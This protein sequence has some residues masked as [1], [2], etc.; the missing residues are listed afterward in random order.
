MSWFLSAVFLFLL[1]L[2]GL[3]ASGGRGVAGDLASYRVTDPNASFFAVD[4]RRNGS[5]PDSRTVALATPLAANGCPRQS[6]ARP[7]DYFVTIPAFYQDRE[8]WREANA[9]FFAF[10]AQVTGFAANYVRTG[11]PGQ[12]H[13]LVH[14]LSSWADRR[15]LL[16]FDYEGNHGQAWYAIQWATA[17]AGLAYSI[18]RS[19]PSLSDQERQE[20]EDWLAA[21]VAKQIGYPGNPISCCNN[22]YY[23]RGLQAAIVGV[24]TG[25]DRLFRYGIRAYQAA[26]KSMNPD[27]SLRHEMDRGKRALHYQNFAILP[28]VFIAE[29]AARQGYDLYGMAIDGRDIHLAVGFLLQAM[30][31]PTV[32]RRYTS[33]EQD[34]RFI[35]RRDELNW[36]E[37]YHRRFSEPVIARWLTRL[38]PLSHNWTGGPGTLYFADLRATALDRTNQALWTTAPLQITSEQRRSTSK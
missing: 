11:E 15:A 33:D 35:D 2:V 4:Q 17:T 20:V 19:E 21:V 9:P 5:W 12:A 32:L 34:L 31:D 25:N 27:G 16:A 36:L 37:P 10:E 7:I 6:L 29:I 38:R 28:L 18:V 22:H 14:L 1:A 8:G 24:V 30:E 26:L 3:A 23:W 13:C